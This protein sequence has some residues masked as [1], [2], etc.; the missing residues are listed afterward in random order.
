MRTVSRTPSPTVLLRI[1]DGPH[2]MHR[3]FN[4]FTQAMESAEA[5]ASAGFAVAMVSATG[6][7]LMRFE[8][9]L[10]RAAI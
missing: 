3:A 2:H 5:F 6:Q 10:Q 7:F 1:S 8:P 4:D 9:R